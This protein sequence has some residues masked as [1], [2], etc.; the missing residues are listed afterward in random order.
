[1]NESASARTKIIFG[2][3]GIDRK[4][5]IRPDIVRARKCAPSRAVCPEME[6]PRVEWMAREQ[7]GR[8]E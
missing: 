3:V 7:E 6:K 5:N 8:R 1:M 4:K 2:R